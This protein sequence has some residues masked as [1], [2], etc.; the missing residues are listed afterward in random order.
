MDQTIKK[1]KKRVFYSYKILKKVKLKNKKK[2]V[3]NLSILS[4]FSYVL[5]LISLGSIIPLIFL[6]LQKDKMMSYVNS[7]E[8]LSIYSYSQIVVLSILSILFFHPLNS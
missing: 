5:E 7:I 4:L 1:L 6:I 3:F 8:L 2:S